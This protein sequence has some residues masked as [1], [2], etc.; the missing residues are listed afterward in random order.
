MTRIL[1][2]RRF[3]QR[4]FTRNYC[5][6]Q[7]RATPSFSKTSPVPAETAHSCENRPLLS[8]IRGVS[9]DADLTR[10]DRGIVEKF[11]DTLRER[12]EAMVTA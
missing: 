9:F 8:D 5:N 4:L 2:H 12:K 6:P 7:F 3:H 11:L 1:K 10:V